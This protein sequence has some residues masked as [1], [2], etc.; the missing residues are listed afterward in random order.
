MCPHPEHGS[1]GEGGAAGVAPAFTTCASFTCWDKHAPNQ[2]VLD[3][4]HPWGAVKRQA[5]RSALPPDTQIL[6]AR[7]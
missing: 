7:G 2:Q 6:A 3:P 5:W 4:R 1:Q